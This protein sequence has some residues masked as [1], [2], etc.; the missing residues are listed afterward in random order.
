MAAR[1]FVEQWAQF[2]GFGDT[3]VGQIVMAC[4]EACANVFC[5]GY[6]KTPGPLRIRAEI[7]GS[8]LIIQITDEAPPVNAKEIRGRQLSDLRPGGLGTVVMSQ[9][10]DEVNYTPLENGNILTLRKALPQNVEAERV[11]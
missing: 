9:V 2:A 5:H 6:H 4:D 7:T 1:S 8:A 10:F 3:I 11:E